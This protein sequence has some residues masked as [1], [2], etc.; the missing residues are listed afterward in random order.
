VFVLGGES[1]MAVYTSS[2]FFIFQHCVDRSSFCW[3]K[4][5]WI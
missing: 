1:S 2:V 3:C 4:I 5:I